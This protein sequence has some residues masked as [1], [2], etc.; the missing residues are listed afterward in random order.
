MKYNSCLHIKL[1]FFIL[2]TSACVNWYVPD[3]VALES[4]QYLSPKLVQDSSAAT[5]SLNPNYG[6][7]EILI[8]LTTT[9]DHEQLASLGPYEVNSL[10]ELDINVFWN[11][12]FNTV[13]HSRSA[14]SQV[15]KAVGNAANAARSFHSASSPPSELYRRIL[16]PLKMSQCLK[17]SKLENSKTHRASDISR[18]HEE[19]NKDEIKYR[20]WILS[21]NQNRWKEVGWNHGFSVIPPNLVSTL[22]YC[23][24]LN[25][26]EDTCTV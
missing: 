26:R 20:S 24:V 22:L 6:R 11:S 19:L 1:L 8:I 9:T 25:R 7:H 2:L 23:T 5:V 16:S 3:D 15:I 13:L 21:N 12:I 4:F 17:T 18:R 10:F 14:E